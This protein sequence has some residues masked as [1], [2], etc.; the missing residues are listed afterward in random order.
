MATLGLSALMLRA[1]PEASRPAS[2]R[3]KLRAYSAS[4]N[5]L[6]LQSLGRRFYADS[7]LKLDIE[8]ARSQ[9]TCPAHVAHRIDDSERERFLEDGYLRPFR[10]VSADQ[11]RGLAQQVSDQAA[12]PGVYGFPSPRDLHLADP[13]V[14]QLLRRPAVV[15]RLAQLMG[16]DLGVWRSELFAKEPGAA[17]IMTHHATVYRFEDR[18]PV[19]QPDESEGL[20]QLTVW[21]ALTDAHVDNGCMYVIP[22][23]HRRPVTFR[24]GGESRFYGFKAVV[25][26]PAI[27][28]PPVPVELEAGEAF[29]FSERVL[30]G[31]YENSSDRR[32]VAL[33]AR[34]IQPNVRVHADKVEHFA[35]HHGETYDLAPWGVWPLCGGDAYRYNRRRTFAD[36]DT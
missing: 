26:D 5:R 17:A 1:L 34:V 18:L 30:H 3:Q 4:E 15:E 19:L 20:F 35:Q 6:W 23:T 32:R 24:K 11:A 21:I 29:I 12:E 36:D 27:P 14:R 22:G 31:S 7:P 33:N 25:P 13:R 28:T 16:P 10:V 2:L 9:G 8:R